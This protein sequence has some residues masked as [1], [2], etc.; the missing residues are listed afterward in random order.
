MQKYDVIVVGA[1]PGGIPAA[2]AAARRGKKVLLI[3]RQP[4]LGGMLASG[5][6]LIG[7]IDRAGNHVVKGIAQEIVD[8]MQEKG[9]TGGHVR[10]P[11]QN[12]LTMMNPN[13]A[14][15][16][17]T[18]MCLDAGVHCMV[19]TEL[20]EVLHEDQHIR[21][22]KAFCRGKIFTFHSDI[23]I[24]GT[25]DAW[26]ADM[27][28]IPWEKGDKLQPPTLCFEVSGV[29]HKA[30]YD[31][32]Q[33]H[34][35]TY[36]LPDTF[37]GVSQ[38]AEMFRDENMF[39]FMGFPDLIEEA[40]KHGEFNIPRN[41]I[42]FCRNPYS[43]RAFLNVT[44]AINADVSI[45]ESFIEA[46]FTCEMQILELYEFL[47]KYA[48]GFQNCKLESIMPFLG[49]RESRRIV[50]RKTL[51]RE[52][53]TTLEIPEDTIALAGYNVDI[54]GQDSGNM[55]YIPLPHAMGIPYGCMLPKT[56]EGFLASGRTI[57]VDQT[58][59]AMTRV[60]APCMAVGQAAGTAACLA[61]DQGIE[62]SQV[63]VAELRA[64]LVI[65][66]AVVSL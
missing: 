4:F 53:L 34:P 12:S 57:S 22:I 24:D 41:M 13:W 20:L 64:E 50:G 10:V 29:D 5:V 16:T 54:H 46:E 39:S 43:D 27:A 28:G 7:F 52:D 40:K 31:Y 15:L 62:V 35:E 45:P 59:F 63:D 37:R 66:G 23:L 38:Y 2:I 19:G 17:V 51:R 33:T 3:E 47:R 48:P 8:R 60:M 55:T 9:G 18:K 14:R 65:D 6:P 36:A 42:D 25:G 21:G 11:L 32:V 44:R 58:V 56:M 49:T 30:F 61:L 1:G 26:A